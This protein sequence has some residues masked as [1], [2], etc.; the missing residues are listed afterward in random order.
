MRDSAFHFPASLR[1]ADFSIKNIKSCGLF[2]GGARSTAECGMR[3]FDLASLRNADFSA[4]Q[5]AGC[6][7]FDFPASLF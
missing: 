3:V 2:G 6:G 5:N 1:N 7:F 4:L